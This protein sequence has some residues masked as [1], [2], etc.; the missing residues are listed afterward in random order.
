MYEKYNLVLRSFSGIPFLQRRLAELCLGNLYATT[1]H[2]INSCVLKLTKRMVACPVYRGFAGA[3]LPA[4]FWSKDAHG[5]AGGVEYGF[6]STTTEREQALHYADG[7]ASTVVEMQLGMVDRGA[8]LSWLSQYQHEREVLLPP[9][10]GQQVLATRV[11]GGTLIVEMRL[12]LNFTSL[13]LEQVLRP[14]HLTHR[15]FETLYVP[16]HG[17]PHSSGGLH[18]PSHGH[19]RSSGGLPRSHPLAAARS[20]CSASARRSCPT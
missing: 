10:T 5:I 8:E 17:R 9:L 1:I 4:S 19:P 2:A 20:R 13:T 12:S 18:V 3:Q 7:A 14:A 15:L 16:S 6:M 11:H